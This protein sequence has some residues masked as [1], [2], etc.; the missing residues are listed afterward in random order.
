ML[1]LITMSCTLKAQERDIRNTYPYPTEEHPASLFFALE[2]VT[3]LY[4]DAYSDKYII[5][6]EGFGDWD[7][8]NFLNYTE[9]EPNDFIQI[10]VNREMFYQVLNDVEKVRD[11]YTAAFD[12][13]DSYELI[14]IFNKD[15]KHF[16]YI[17]K[18]VAEA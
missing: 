12:L 13:N 4:Y 10:V 7:N 1:S 6:Y 18:K 14:E 5:T 17:L 11:D 8:Y 3:N 2:E 16:Y 15:T 9:E